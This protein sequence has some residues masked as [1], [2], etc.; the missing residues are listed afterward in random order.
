LSISYKGGRCWAA[1]FSPQV[2]SGQPGRV[3][4]PFAR[5]ARN[6]VGYTSIL[7]EVNYLPPSRAASAAE[8]A[9]PD[10]RCSNTAARITPQSMQTKN[11]PSDPLRFANAELELLC[12]DFLAQSLSFAGKFVQIAGLHKDFASRIEGMIVTRCSEV[13]AEAQVSLAKST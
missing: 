3:F 4:L 7:V 12:D 5:A 10:V 8:I 9:T 11:V 1:K 2:R 13:I 6:G